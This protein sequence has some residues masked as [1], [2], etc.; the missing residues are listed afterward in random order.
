MEHQNQTLIGEFILIGFPQDTQTCIIFF[1]ALSLMYIFTVCGNII[2]IAG[3]ITSPK[4]HLPMYFFLC[5][6]SFIDLCFSSTF[7][8]KAMIDIFSIRRTISVTGCMDRYAAIS[9]PLYYNTIMKWNTCRKIIIVKWPGNF[10]ISVVPF[11]SLP[12]VFCIGDT[13]DHFVCEML[14]V[15]E[16]A[17][18]NLT[19]FKFTIV[20]VGFLTLV[21]P[22]VFIV[23]SYV[24]IIS[25]ILKIRSTNG[26][27]KAFSTCASHLIVVSMYYGTCIGVYMGEIKRFSSNGK[28]ISL[29]YGV[30]TPV[31][32]PLIYSLRNKDVKDT[33]QKILIRVHH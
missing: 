8:P 16:L 30:L 32:N 7:I 29:I 9:L 20:A 21:L 2:L 23:V 26:R 4:L 24:L 17:C 27:S 19:F 10:L 3:I 33:F 11:I 6:L 31:L 13:L 25:S 14:A 28:Y 1:L 15:L 18:G 5:N 12:L 22:L